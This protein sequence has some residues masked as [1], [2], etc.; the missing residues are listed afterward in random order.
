MKIKKKKLHGSRRRILIVFISD[1][2]YFIHKKSEI[3]EEVH[4]SQLRKM[5]KG[6]DSLTSRKDIYLP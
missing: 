1:R 3:K 2:I 4:A 6:K 5:I